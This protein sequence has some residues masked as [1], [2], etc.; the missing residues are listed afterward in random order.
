MIAPT[1][2]AIKTSSRMSNAH[3]EKVYL[4]L[5]SFLREVKAEAKMLWKESLPEERRGTGQSFSSLW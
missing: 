3:D 4:A 5:R 1:V 2:S